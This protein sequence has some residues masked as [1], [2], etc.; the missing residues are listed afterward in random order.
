MAKI[1]VLLAGG[2]AAGRVIDVEDTDVSAS[3]TVPGLPAYGPDV[4]TPCTPP[5]TE[6]LTYVPTAETAS[7]YR[8]W[9]WQE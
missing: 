4:I 3:V 9:R 6:Q 2:R 8:V 1:K 7:G 5:P